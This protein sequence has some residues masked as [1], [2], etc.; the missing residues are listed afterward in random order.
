VS[1][2]HNT[3]R[4]TPAYFEAAPSAPARPST[5]LFFPVQSSTLRAARILHQSTQEVECQEAPKSLSKRDS[6]DQMH[7]TIPL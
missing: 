6:G 2:K 4:R 3:R 5:Q 7:I 1:L